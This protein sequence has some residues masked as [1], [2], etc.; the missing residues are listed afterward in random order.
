MFTNNPAGVTGP[1]QVAVDL[2]TGIASLSD[3]IEK[4]TGILQNT[5]PGGDRFQAGS[6]CINITQSTM[7]AAMSI[8]ASSCL[9][10][11]QKY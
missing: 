7:G 6:N 11:V 2:S 4:F 3:F 8:D 9:A 5:M 1:N 10:C